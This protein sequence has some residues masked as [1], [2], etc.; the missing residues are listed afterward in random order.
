MLFTVDEA[1]SLK[2]TIARVKELGEEYKTYA[3]VVNA[4][5]IWFF[6]LI[7]VKSLIVSTVLVSMY[8]QEPDLIVTWNKGEGLYFFLGYLFISCL[9]LIGRLVDFIAPI[10]VVVAAFTIGKG[11]TSNFTPFVL[12]IAITYAVTFGLIFFSNSLI[13]SI[14]KSSCPKIY[15]E[16]KLLSEPDEFTRICYDFDVCAR[17]AE[18]DANNKDKHDVEVAEDKKAETESAKNKDSSGGNTSGHYDDGF[19]DDMI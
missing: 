15:D 12:P 16:I 8:R 5:S 4:F 17:N 7:T 13:N 1:R 3:G 10:A 2:P 19:Y 18:Y 6:I 9:P 11:I 14:I